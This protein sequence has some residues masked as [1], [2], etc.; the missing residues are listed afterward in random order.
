MRNSNVK[1]LT[2]KNPLPT[3][4]M[5]HQMSIIAV[6]EQFF[7]LKPSL[8]TVAYKDH[9]CKPKIDDNSHIIHHTKKRDILF[10][11]NQTLIL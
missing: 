6:H 2:I 8:L 9:L 4:W 11:S 5:L 10:E 7:N 1:K 3:K